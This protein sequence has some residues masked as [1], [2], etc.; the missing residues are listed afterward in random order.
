MSARFFPSSMV[1]QE[2]AASSRKT[3]DASSQAGSTQFTKYA[4]T[5][6]NASVDLISDMLPKSLWI[7]RR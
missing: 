6:P 4:C 5:N 1:P 3:D 2:A 7:R